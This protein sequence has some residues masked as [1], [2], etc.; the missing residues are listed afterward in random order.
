VLS[1]HRRAVVENL[2]RREARLPDANRCQTAF[3]AMK[4]G[5]FAV[6]LRG[7]RHGRAIVLEQIRFLIEQTGVLFERKR[8]V[9][10]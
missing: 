8:V 10:D 3:S 1:N 9:F 6:A 2:T 4:R 7:V 5:F